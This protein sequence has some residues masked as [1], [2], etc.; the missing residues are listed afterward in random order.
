[1]WGRTYARQQQARDARRAEAQASTVGADN[2]SP[3]EGMTKK[4]ARL[5]AKLIGL[6]SR[7][8]GFQIS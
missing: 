4:V 7:G 3:K 5:M 8:I 1:M 6:N 2:N